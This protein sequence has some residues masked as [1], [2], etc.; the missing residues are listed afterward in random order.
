MR[1]RQ[2]RWSPAVDPV[3][4]KRRRRRRISRLAKPWYARGAPAA[5]IEHF[6][7]AHRLHPTN[8]TYRRDAWSLAGAEREAVYG[9]SWVAE[10]KREGIENY[11]PRLRL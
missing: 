11:Y 3:R 6:R 10:V 2:M 5:A 4:S 9:T 1:F 7:A 8:W